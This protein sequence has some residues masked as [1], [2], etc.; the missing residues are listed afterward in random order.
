M[1]FSVIIDGKNVECNVIGVFNC[2]NKNFVIYT[3][4]DSV[5]EIYA[6][7]YELDENNNMILLPIEDSQDWDLVDKYLEEVQ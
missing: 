2:D 6:S 5:D 7:F 3:E 1:G 4:S